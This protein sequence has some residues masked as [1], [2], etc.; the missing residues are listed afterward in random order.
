[1]KKVIVIIFGTVLLFLGNSCVVKT[2]P[3]ASRTVVVLRAPINHKIVI[4]KGKRYYTWGGKRYS[5]TRR[6]YVV[7]SI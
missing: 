2:R 5:K 4:I 7:V 6:G 3:V 1:M